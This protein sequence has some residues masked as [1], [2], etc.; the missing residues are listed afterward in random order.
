MNWKGLETITLRHHRA[1]RLVSKDTMKI[2][3]LQYVRWDNMVVNIDCQTD[4]VDS[5]LGVSTVNRPGRYLVEI[6]RPTTK[7]G[8][9]HSMDWAPGQSKRREPAEHTQ[10]WRSAS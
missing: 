8:Q 3:N 2:L 5:Y 9:H 1:V 10:S 4:R 6:R 7:N